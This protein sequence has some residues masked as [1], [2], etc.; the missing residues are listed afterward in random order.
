MQARRFPPRRTCRSPAARR[1][2]RRRTVMESAARRRGR[3]SVRA[4]AERPGFVVFPPSQFRPSPESVSTPSSRFPTPRPD[5]AALANPAG[6]VETGWVRSRR[7]AGDYSSNRQRL[8]GF[9]SPI[10]PRRK[11]SPN[12][13]ASHRRVAHRPGFGLP[14]GDSELRSSPPGRPAA[15]RSFPWEAFAGNR[16][17]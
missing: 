8:G 4:M 1:P 12:S 6:W 9:V 5:F 15:N 17:K 7:S 16:R 10:L 11:N 13:P 2:G 14:H 3:A